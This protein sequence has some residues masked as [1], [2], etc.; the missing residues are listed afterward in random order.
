MS[1]IY[2]HVNNK[3]AKKIYFLMYHPHPEFL[4]NTQYSSIFKISII[5]YQR[6][7]KLINK[8]L[9]FKQST[10]IHIQFWYDKAEFF[11]LTLLQNKEDYN[12]I[13]VSVVRSFNKVVTEIVL[14]F[15]TIG[16]FELS[17]RSQMAYFTNMDCFSV[18][19]QIT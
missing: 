7:M 11:L 13:P 16:N 3:L 8:Y 18:T 2:K 15:E 4:G 5:Q 1:L 12:E 17:L 14:Y 6:F 10:C 9:F 19:K